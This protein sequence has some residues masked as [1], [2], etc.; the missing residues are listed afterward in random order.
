M[1]MAGFLTLANRGY[2]VPFDTANGQLVLLAA[3]ACFG[4]AF[5]WLAKLMRDRDNTRILANVAE[6]ANAGVV[7]RS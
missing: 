1:A 4:F 5:F 3:G 2:L 7:V 6:S